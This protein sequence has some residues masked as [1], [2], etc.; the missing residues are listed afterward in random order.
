M[1]TFLFHTNTKFNLTLIGIKF[2]FNIF[3]AFVLGTIDQ[4]YNILTF[5]PGTIYKNNWWHN[6]I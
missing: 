6:Q 3:I 2:L 5:V 1:L 4:N